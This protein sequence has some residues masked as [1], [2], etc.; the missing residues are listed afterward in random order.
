MSDREALPR[1]PG[2]TFNA[3]LE[4]GDL[5]LQACT[6]CGR[7]IFF[8]RTLCPHCGSNDLEWR[9]AS[10]RGVVYSTTIV[11]Q[12]PERGGDYNVA[13]IELAEGARM[14]S[15]VEELPATEVRIGMAVEAVIRKVNGQSL[16]LFRPVQGAS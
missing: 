13:L 2:D 11:R 8:P 15:R 7:Q 4:A 16:V 9:R 12:K 10:G 1:A 14:L 5:R 6:R 3:F